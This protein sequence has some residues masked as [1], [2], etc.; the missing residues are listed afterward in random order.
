VGE[1]SFMPIHFLANYVRPF[2]LNDLRKTAREMKG[3]DGARFLA[4]LAMKGA[5]E[6]GDNLALANAKERL[7]RAQLLGGDRRTIDIEHAERMRKLELLVAPLFKFLPDLKRPKKEAEDDPLGLLAREVSA[8]VG[9]GAQIVLWAVDGIIKPAIFCLDMKTA[10][11]VHTFFLAPSGGLGF[12]VCPYDGEQFF[13]KR[14]NQDYCRPA[15]REAHRIAR[16]RNDKKL[17]AIETNRGA[18]V[19]KKAR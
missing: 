13:Q 17:R 2:T 9:Y 5:L 18:D 4:V 6:A 12:R 16:W 15:H 19:T 1:A 3:E 14:P 11:Y 8:I 7:K 10:L